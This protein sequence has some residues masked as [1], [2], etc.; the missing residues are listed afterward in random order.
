MIFMLHRQARDCLTGR[1]LYLFLCLSTT[2]AANRFWPGSAASSILWTNHPSS[3]GRASSTLSATLVGIGQAL[4]IISLGFG[5]VSEARAGW[6]RMISQEREIDGIFIEQKGRIHN[7][8]VVREKRSTR[9]KGPA[10]CR[11][12]FCLFFFT[13]LR[14]AYLVMVFV[15]RWERVPLDGRDWCIVESLTSGRGG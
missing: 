6:D 8:R 4:S 2:H 13:T 15:E 5:F 9:Q 1:L 10:V 7:F 14:S 3:L 11:F 12:F